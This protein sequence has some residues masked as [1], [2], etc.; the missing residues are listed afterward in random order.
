MHDKCRRTD[1]KKW[2]CSKYVLSGQK[3]CDKHMH[4]DGDGQKFPV[5]GLEAQL[6]RISVEKNTNSC[7]T[8]TTVTDI[9]LRGEEDN[10]EVLQLCSSGV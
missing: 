8:D 7:S 5:S 6:S 4:R 3:Y 10:E 1:G 9:A 2:R